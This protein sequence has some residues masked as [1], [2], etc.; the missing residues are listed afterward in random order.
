MGGNG[1]E[2]EE[3]DPRQFNELNYNNAATTIFRAMGP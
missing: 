1:L 3:D 2:E